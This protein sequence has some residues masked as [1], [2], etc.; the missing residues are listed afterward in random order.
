MKETI[1]KKKRAR[2]PQD[3]M[4]MVSFIKGQIP[5]GGLDLR[6]CDSRQAFSWNSV[7]FSGCR[8]FLNRNAQTGNLFF[9][10]FSRICG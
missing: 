3:V 4:R 8:N 7:V 2:R 1:R 6:I 9:G 10:F 5:V